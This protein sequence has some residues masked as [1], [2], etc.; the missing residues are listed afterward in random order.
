MQFNPFLKYSYKLNGESIV[1]IS[2]GPNITEKAEES[3]DEGGF[4]LPINVRGIEYEM[5]GTLEIEIKDS[6]NN[7]RSFTYLIIFDEV[8]KTSVYG[9]F[10][11][12][13]RVVEYTN[14]LNSYFV[15]TLIKTF[16]NQRIN[17]PAR[18]RI[19]RNGYLRTEY[20]TNDRAY[21]VIMPFIDIKEQIL[22]KN[23]SFT[24]KGNVGQVDYIHIP[25]FSSTDITIEQA[26]AFVMLDND[27]STKKNI[28]SGDA[29]FTNVEQGEHTIQYGLMNVPDLLNENLEDPPPNRCCDI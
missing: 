4:N 5:N 12:S 22:T 28:S 24:I 1:G 9:W 23:G 2:L 25:S 17:N 6:R 21:R 18:R 16:P 15:D 29:V 19:P 26:N 14:K 13:L 3:F 10:T 27:I 20:T 11:H 8:H 7:V